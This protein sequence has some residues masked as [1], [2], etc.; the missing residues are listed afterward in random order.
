L[1]KLSESSAR[2]FIEQRQ[3][4]KVL[5]WTVVLALLPGVLLNA[6][7]FGI[8]IFIQ[9]FIALI[10]VV[11]I[12]EAIALLRGQ[13]IGNSISDGTAVVLVSIV[14]ISMP[15]YGHWWMCSMA[16]GCATIFGKHIY[17]GTGQNLFNPAMVGVVFALV[18]FPS[19]STYWPSGNDVNLLSM[20]EGLKLI[21]TPSQ[22][23]LDAISGATLLE[24]ERTQLSFAVMRSEFADS[25]LYGLFA[26][27]GWEWVN[28]AYLCGGL[29]LC[30]RR[31][32]SYVVP[33]F[34]LG[35]LFVCAS[36][37][38]SIDHT[39]FAGPLLHCF[40]GGAMMCAFFVATDPVSSPTGRLAAIVYAVLLGIFVYTFRNIGAYPEA[41]AFAV[42]LLN[43]LAPLL[44]RL[45]SRQIYGH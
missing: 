32:I 39:R 31:V 34:F 45:C 3:S 17:G 11:I 27:R 7:F 24:Y 38:Y 26:E 30:F 28:L 22:M 14:A 6:F 36:V 23:G 8:G 42:L 41:V 5:M 15:T 40:S 13:K 4:V 35:S 25:A 1:G 37:M 44:D 20:T 10:T 29:W 16:A 2:P 18:C 21:F 9:L 43:A 19:I 33:V 12:D